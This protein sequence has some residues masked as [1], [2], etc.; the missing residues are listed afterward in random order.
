MP[1]I[2]AEK[3]T[4]MNWSYGDGDPQ[5]LLELKRRIAATARARRTIPYSELV[6]GVTFRLP[7]VAEGAPFQLGELGVWTELDRSILGSFLGRISADSY[8][9]GR[10][11]ASAVAVSM[12]TN[13]P[14]EGFRNLVR[15]IGLMPKGR[16][17]FVLFWSEQLTKAYDWYASHPST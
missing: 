1:N 14:S 16:D 8:L 6:K 5:A 9:E 15:D 3:L 2:V 10:F 17:A 4:R 12:S 11:L 7:N 13:E